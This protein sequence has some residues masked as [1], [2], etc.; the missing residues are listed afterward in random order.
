MKKRS[1]LIKLLAIAAAAS[2]FSKERITI[3]GGEMD[4]KSNVKATYSNPGRLYLDGDFELVPKDSY[5]WT[6]YLGNTELTKEEFFMITGREDL[7]EM[8]ANGLKKEKDMHIAGYSLFGIGTAFTATSLIL[9]A[10]GNEFITENI[11]PFVVSGIGEVLLSLPFISYEFKDGVNI[12][13]AIQIAS[14]YNLC[15]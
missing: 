7:R 1:L 12:T 4:L 3:I 11:Y 5:E 2:V 8:I 10:A 9:Y 6:A 15:K 13:A 14:D